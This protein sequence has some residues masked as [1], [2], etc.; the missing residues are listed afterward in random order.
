MDCEIER[1]T[2]AVHFSR[3]IQGEA[4]VTGQGIQNWDAFKPSDAKK[5][6]KQPPKDYQYFVVSSWEHEE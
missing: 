1:R 5:L 3:E 4:L 6:I 2:C